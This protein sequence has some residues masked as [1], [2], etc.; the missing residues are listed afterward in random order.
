MKLHNA[1]EVEAK[2]AFHTDR[3]EA[4]RTSEK[5]KPWAARAAAILRLGNRLLS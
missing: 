5:R 4:P 1:T 3:F 2:A